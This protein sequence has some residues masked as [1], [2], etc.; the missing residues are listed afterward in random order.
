MNIDDELNV[1]SQ[2]YHLTCNGRYD[3]VL[4]AP[5]EHDYIIRAIG[6]DRQSGKWTRPSKKLPS[7]EMVSSRTLDIFTLAGSQKYPDFQCSE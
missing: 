3:A 2:S 1:K 7:A 5:R 6:S 4:V